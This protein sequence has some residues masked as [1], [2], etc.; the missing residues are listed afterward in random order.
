MVNEDWKVSLMKALDE[1]TVEIF[2]KHESTG[3]PIGDDDFIEKV[4]I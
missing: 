1:D 2:R 4:E 3:R